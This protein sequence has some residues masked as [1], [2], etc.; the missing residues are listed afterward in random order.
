MIN[1]R[2]LLQQ[3]GLFP[4][5]AIGASAAPPPLSRL[6]LGLVTYNWGSRWDLPTLID[7]C[8]RTGFTGLELRTTH[9]HGVELALDASAREE[10]RRRFA[11]SPV[12]LVG[13][14]TTCEYHAPDPALVRKNIE[15]TKAWT[16]LCHDIGGSGVKVRPNGLPPGVSRDRTIEQIGRS[17]NEVARDAADH[18]VQI[19]LEVHGAGTADVPTCRA[20]MDIADQPANVICWN[21]NPSDLEGA[22]FDA[23]FDLLRDRIGTVHIHDLRRDGY[24]WPALF[25]RL[26]SCNADSFTGWTL[27]EEAAVPDD[28]EAA[29]VQNRKIWEQLAK[30]AP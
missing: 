4:I 18:G 21:C 28:I 12:K 19:R 25:R 22:G 20:I 10:I 2:S 1:R 11:D 23:N 17:L 13:L 16:R 26:H 7:T 3:V 15:E 30:T 5:A 27:L 8:R 14:G 6:R 9:P 29:M 24:P